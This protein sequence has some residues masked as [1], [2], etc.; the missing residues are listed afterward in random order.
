M[1]DTLA[2]VRARLGL[3]ADAD[4]AAVLAAL[5]T[6]APDNEPDDDP[7]P[8]AETEEDEADEEETDEAAPGTVLIDEGVLAQLRSDA[9]AGRAARLQQ[10]AEHRENLVNAAV[11][12]GRISLARKADWL[13]KLE[14]DKGSESEL[15]S[16][17]KGLVPV[18]GPRGYTG[19]LGDVAEDND[20]MTYKAL[21]G[22]AV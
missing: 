3:S 13:N 1:P 22:E 17:A 20:E 15:A 16:L 2:K 9:E 19:S 7:A 11:R 6:V 12:D 10:L 14:K 4:E 21:F 5:D 8:D 18:D